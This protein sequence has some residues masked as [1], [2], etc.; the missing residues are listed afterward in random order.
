VA[1]NISNLL[2]RLDRL[3]AQVG[4]GEGGQGWGPAM[5]ITFTKFWN[6]RSTIPGGDFG[7][8]QDEDGT[9]TGRWQEQAAI[10][11]ALDQVRAEA[12]ERRQP[13]G[14]VSAKIADDGHVALA[15][16]PW[17]PD[18]PELSWLP[19]SRRW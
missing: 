16:I 7:D 6:G 5:V 8:D 10:E 19:K 4:D 9:A 3:E 12:R 18:D 11:A 14:I 15:G 1:A 2:R 17:Q 13:L